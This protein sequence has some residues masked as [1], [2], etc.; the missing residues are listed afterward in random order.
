MSTVG[1][2]IEDKNGLTALPN[3]AVVVETR[4][5]VLVAGPTVFQYFDDGIWGVPG[6]E[7]MIRTDEIS[8]PVKVIYLPQG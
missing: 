5:H 3:G 7:D 1:D 2:I 6:I 8:L 4:A